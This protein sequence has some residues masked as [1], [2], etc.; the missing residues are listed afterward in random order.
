MYFINP[1]HIIPVYNIFVIMSSVTELYD[2]IVFGYI[3]SPYCFSFSLYI[4]IFVLLEDQGLPDE[5]L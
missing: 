1:S 2:M 5:V 4:T 3:P